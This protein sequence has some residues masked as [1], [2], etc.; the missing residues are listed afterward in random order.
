LVLDADAVGKFEFSNSLEVINF[1]AT[2]LDDRAID[3]LLRIKSLWKLSLRDCPISNA[4]KSR[5]RAAI[6]DVDVGP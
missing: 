3:A 1:N 5:L 2:D 4:G 6:R